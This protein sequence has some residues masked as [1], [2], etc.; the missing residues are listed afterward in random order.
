M[1]GTI[2]QPVAAAFRRVATHDH[3]THRHAPVH[4]FGAELH[5]GTRPHPERH[6]RGGGRSLRRG[7][8]PIL[9][10]PS[11]LFAALGTRRARD[12]AGLMRARAALRRCGLHLGTRAQLVELILLPQPLI[13]EVSG[14]KEAP[15]LMTLLRTATPTKMPE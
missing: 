8:L 10:K 7:C 6:A 11:Q 3:P 12:R 14:T 4:V 5:V 15:M 2:D 9:P 1:L 13:N